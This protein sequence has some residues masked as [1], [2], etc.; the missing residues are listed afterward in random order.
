MRSI[1]KDWKAAKIRVCVHIACIYHALHCFSLLSRCVYCIHLN[2]RLYIYIHISSIT[3]ALD[4]LARNETKDAHS[5]PHKNPTNLF[6]DRNAMLM[7]IKRL[8]IELFPLNIDTYAPNEYQLPSV[9]VE[10]VW[11]EDVWLEQARHIDIHT[12]DMTKNVHYQPSPLVFNAI[13]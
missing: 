8:Y 2:T 7:D 1:T 4:Y 3:F 13:C 5:A 6:C 10:Y 9:V 12:H 11:C